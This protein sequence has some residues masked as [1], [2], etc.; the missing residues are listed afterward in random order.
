MAAAIIELKKVSKQFGSKLALDNVSMVVEK[1]QIFGF[2][3]PNGAG[4]TTTIRC[5]MDFIRPTGGAVKLFGKPLD[6]LDI[7]YKNKIGFLSADSVLYGN[8]SGNAHIKFI[9]TMHGSRGVADQLVSRFDLDLRPKVRHLS[10]G[11]KQKLAL[12]LALMHEPDLL[13]LDEPTRGLDPIL[14]QEIYSILRELRREG[15]TVFMS[16]HNLAEVEQICDRVG[17]IREGKIVA[18]ESMQSVRGMQMHIVKVVFATTYNIRDYQIDKV[19][20]KSSSKKELELHV[21]GDLNVLLTRLLRHPIRD[22]DISHASLED[23]FMR[24]YQ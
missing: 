7:N 16:S 18:S 1:G 19:D 23:V 12:V 9:A 6:R 5:L 20:I 13:V 10:S 24:F 8:W 3:G 2:L 11:N 4:K 22:I 14:Q 21:H 17:I 15:K